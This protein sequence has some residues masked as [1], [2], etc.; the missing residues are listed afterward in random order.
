MNLKHI[1]A[2]LFV[3]CTVFTSCAV[4][5]DEIFDQPATLRAD[6]TA[7]AY[8]DILTGAQNGWVMEYYPSS[9]QT[10]GGFVVACKF[11]ANGTVDVTADYATDSK[12][13]YTTNSLYQI[14]QTDGMTLSFDTYNEVLHYLSDPSFSHGAG[15]GDGYEGDFDFSI[16][17][18]TSEKVVLKG[19]KTGSVAEM[20]PLKT[21]AEEYLGQ[22]QKMKDESNSPSYIS[23]VTVGEE[24]ITIKY[25]I[26]GQLL[27]YQYTQDGETIDGEIPFVYT[28][29][30]LKFFEAEEIFGKEVSEWVWNGTTFDT[31]AGVVEPF[32]SYVD[33]FMNGQWFLGFEATGIKDNENWNFVWTDYALPVYEQE[34]EELQYLYFGKRNGIFSFNMYSYSAA[35]G[36]SYVASAYLQAPYVYAVNDHTIQMGLNNDNF[37]DSNAQY[38]QESMSY[39]FYI[40]NGEFTIDFDDVKNPTKVILTDT[41]YGDVWTLYATPLQW[42]LEN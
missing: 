8:N 37:G 24:Q 20:Y 1:I 16:I 21:T 27:N 15:K 36:G 11:N 32:V 33:I 18:C 40:F 25:S 39:F 35:A 2:S 19:T 7:K 30:G 17:S 14:C 41:Q 23:N 3:A 12:G 38:Y 13:S 34:G 28:T 42:V 5:E 22:I 10:Y 6:A 26:E 9:Y 29:T 4:E 31:A